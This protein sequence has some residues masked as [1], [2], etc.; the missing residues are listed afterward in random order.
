MRIVVVEL[1]AAGMKLSKAELRDARRHAG[2][3]FIDA[4]VAYLCA[5]DRPSEW[6][7]H[8]QLL[9][10]LY[11]QRVRKLRGD[12]FVIVGRYMRDAINVHVEQ[13]QAWWCRLD[14]IS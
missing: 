3:L 1:R 9:P 5:G 14:C 12:N 2:E 7:A 8:G 10:P 6:P 13:P 4:G 11:E